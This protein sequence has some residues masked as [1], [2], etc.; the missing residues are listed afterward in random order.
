MRLQARPSSRCA[1]LWEEEG[2]SAR[3]L[4]I[5]PDADQLTSLKFALQE[6]G[7]SVEVARDG[8][9][10]FAKFKEL[11][12]N[13]VITELMMDGLSGFELS[14]RITSSD[15]FRPPVFF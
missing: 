7:Y 8:M 13:L 15:E 10:G 2:M 14:S 4:I 12:P 3:V 5:D 1:R 9:E 11:Q 6:E